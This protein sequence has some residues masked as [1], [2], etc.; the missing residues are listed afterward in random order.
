MTVGKTPRIKT[1]FIEINLQSFETFLKMFKFKGIGTP[2][3]ERFFFLMNRY[4]WLSS[5][6]V[7]SSQYLC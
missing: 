6:L 5:H 1:G 4:K 2:V 3:P 7:A